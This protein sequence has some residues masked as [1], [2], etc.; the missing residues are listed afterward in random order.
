MFTI[1]SGDP[2]AILYVIKDRI[3]RYIAVDKNHPLHE[4]EVECWEDEVLPAIEKYLVIAEEVFE[5]A[6]Y[7]NV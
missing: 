3:A 4:R 5:E 7:E 1:H 2:A 6:E